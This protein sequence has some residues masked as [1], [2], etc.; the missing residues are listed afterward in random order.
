M[1]AKERTA[2]AARRQTQQGIAE[3]LGQTDVARVRW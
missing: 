3:I 2:S 1:A